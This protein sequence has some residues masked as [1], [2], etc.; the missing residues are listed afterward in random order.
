MKW[1]KYNWLMILLDIR[2]ARK[3]AHINRNRFKYDKYGLQVAQRKVVHQW[4]N[5]ER[6]R[7]YHSIYGE[8]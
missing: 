5:A 7:I 3:L 4:A 2:Y 6:D 8:L 1:L